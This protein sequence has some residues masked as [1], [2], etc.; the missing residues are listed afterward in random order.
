MSR[1]VNEF[2]TQPL[3]RRE[4]LAAGSLAVIAAS[5][6][7]HQLTAPTDFETELPIPPVLTPVKS[8][9]TTDYYEMT[10]RQTWAEIIPRTRTQ[11][12]CYNGTFPGPTIKARRGR[13]TVVTHTNQLSIPTVA[14]L[15]GGVTKPDSDGFPTDT[16]APGESRRYEYG[17]SGPPAPVS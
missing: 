14:H 2:V 1:Q 4:F 16:V 15:H 11:V 5:Q 6:H 12:R 8:D 9:S 3:N 7:M 10:Q 13:R 17:N